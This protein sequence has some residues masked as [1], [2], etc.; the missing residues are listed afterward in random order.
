MATLINT[1]KKIDFDILKMD[2]TN[3]IILLLVSLIT[4]VAIGPQL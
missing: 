2:F 3:K 4:V 1:V